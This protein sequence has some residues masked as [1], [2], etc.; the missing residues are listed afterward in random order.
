[1]KL[2]VLLAGALAGT[3]LAALA[4]PL[5]PKGPPVRW[6]CGGIGSD[7]RRMLEAHRADADLELLFVTQKR[8]GY[9]AGA[10]VVVKRDA[11]TVAS[12]EAD[13]PICLLG[14]PPGAYRVE[15]S[16]AG[17]TVNRNIR[18]PATHRS[19]RA[20]FTFSDEPSD[21]IE[22]SEEEKRQARE[23]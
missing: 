5:P 7:E 16:L 15:A 4:Q 6:T 18:V 23:P 21:G 3:T 13:G 22:A 8:G 20:V 2:A 9:V 10:S 17:A 12:F 11:A 14:L 1:M 19:Q